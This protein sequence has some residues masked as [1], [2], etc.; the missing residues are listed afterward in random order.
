MVWIINQRGQLLNIGK[1]IKLRYSR[2]VDP[3]IGHALTM[4]I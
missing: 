2:Y 4:Q 1:C 3:L